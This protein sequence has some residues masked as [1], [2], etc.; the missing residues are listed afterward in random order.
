MGAT[1][2]RPGDIYHPDFSDGH[3]A[4]FDISVRNTLQLGNP[5]RASTDDVAATIAREMEKDNK[6]LGLLSRL[7]AVS[8]HSSLK[9]WKSGLLQ[10]YFCFVP[11]LREP[12][13]NGLAVH[14]HL[15]LNAATLGKAVVVHC[16]DDLIALWSPAD[17]GPSFKCICVISLINIVSYFYIFYFKLI[18]VLQSVIIVIVLLL[19]YYK[20]SFCLFCYCFDV[21]IYVYN[22]IIL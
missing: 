5:N 11:S 7:V 1:R 17:N 21:H 9:R 8:F 22:N 14:R 2:Q 12:L 19:S 13:R 20:Y 10:V 4:Y 3:P 15:Q 16:Q 18:C 6:M